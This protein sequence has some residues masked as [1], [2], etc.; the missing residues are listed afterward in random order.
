MKATGNLIVDLSFEFSLDIID[1][2]D[3]LETKRKYVIAKQ[4]CRCGTSVGANVKESQS[5][6]SRNDFIHKLKIASK[7]AE[8]KEYWLL[9][10]KYSKHL[11]DPGPL[12]P[13]IIRIKKI[14]SVIIASTHAN[15]KNQHIAKRG[16]PSNS[17]AEHITP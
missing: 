2:T 10:C 6:E 17:E 13:K 14:L 15:K 16:T 3:Q 12:L 5:A 4:L 7:E 11:P 9:L 1:L 8:E